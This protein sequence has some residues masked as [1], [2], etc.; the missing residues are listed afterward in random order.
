MLILFGLFG[1]KLAEAQIPIEKAL[2]K[3]AWEVGRSQTRLKEGLHLLDVL[4]P[5]LLSVAF[6]RIQKSNPRRER[7][8]RLPFSTRC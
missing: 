1:L 4:V 5:L 6:A 8:F 2:A 7:H 3:S